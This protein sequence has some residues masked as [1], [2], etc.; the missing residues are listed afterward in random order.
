MLLLLY[1]QT[2]TGKHGRLRQR[3]SRLH[4]KQALQISQVKEMF[5]H[6]FTVYLIAYSQIELYF[7]V[8][9]NFFVGSSTSALQQR[10]DDRVHKLR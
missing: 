8:G 10:Q 3:L 1:R 7:Q 5:E 4:F 6:P 9:S 2:G